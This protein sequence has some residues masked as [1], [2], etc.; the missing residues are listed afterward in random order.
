MPILENL[1]IRGLKTT[2]DSCINSLLLK[3]KVEAMA[4]LG[5]HFI[6]LADQRRQTFTSF[7]FNPDFHPLFGSNPY[8]VKLDK[9]LS[10]INP[11][12]YALLTKY[13]QIIN[14]QF[15]HKNKQTDQYVYF[16][17]EHA[18]DVHKVPEGARLKILPF[19]YDSQNI[20][21]ATLVIIEPI[22]YAGSAVLKKHYTNE[23]KTK[24]Y[25]L[26]SKRFVPEE[27]TLLSNIECTIIHLSGMG[28]KEKDIAKQLD[29]TL[30]GLKRVKTVIFEKLKVNSISEA[31]FVA[32]KRRY[33]NS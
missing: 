17:I 12:E 1:L 18:F 24:V 16:T 8:A 30:S 25:N 4:T 13:I 22:Q 14:T 5:Q 29:L 11:S 10:L 3:A 32:Y 7:N 33:I 6:F 26:L 21:L 20:L 23:N 27:S 19:L 2:E 28:V 15:T 9:V 31:I